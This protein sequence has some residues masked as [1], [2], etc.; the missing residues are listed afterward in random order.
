[1]RIFRESLTRVF[2]RFPR[3]LLATAAA[4]LS[5][6]AGIL[7]LF[8]MLASEAVR[9]DRPLLMLAVCSVA[10]I[11]LG[12][13][14]PAVFTRM[15]KELWWLWPCLIAAPSL[16]IGVQALVMDEPSWLY[17]GILLLAVSLWGSYRSHRSPSRRLAASQ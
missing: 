16:W 11:P 8:W 12:Y 15:L 2:Q 4:V 14:I 17:P 10:F 5:A 3:Y 7:C 6:L 1:M 13:V 9:G